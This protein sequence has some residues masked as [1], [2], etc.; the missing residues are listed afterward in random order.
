MLNECSRCCSPWT[1]P[2]LLQVGCPL[3][4]LLLRTLSSCLWAYIQ[5][6]VHYFDCKFLLKFFFIYLFCIRIRRLRSTCNFLI[7]T[8]ALLFSIMATNTVA[9]RIIGAYWP[10]LTL[11]QCF[12]AMSP[13]IIVVEMLTMMPIVIGMERCFEVFFPT[14]DIRFS[15]L[16][17]HKFHKKRS[18]IV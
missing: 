6:K 4:F 13:Y 17:I 9:I 1:W 11:T 18:K 16:K 7:A 8:D 14:F 15:V 10:Q 5:S 3:A 12:L 2:I